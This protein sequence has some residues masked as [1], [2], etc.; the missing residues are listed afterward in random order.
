MA[1]D[2][3]FVALRERMA[4]VDV[5]SNS[6]YV[7][8]REVSSSSA[9]GVLARCAIARAFV[10]EMDDDGDR[11]WGESKTAD[12][13]EGGVGRTLNFCVCGLRLDAELVSGIVS[14]LFADK[15]RRSSCM[16][17]EVSLSFFRLSSDFFC[18]ASWPWP[19]AV[20]SAKRHCAVMCGIVNQEKCERPKFN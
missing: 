14:R 1:Y 16:P 11:F 19:V 10:E 18:R 12:V 17:W 3:I 5:S 13:A 8:A 4:R 7:C 20:V 15:Q 6:G 9:M 2:D